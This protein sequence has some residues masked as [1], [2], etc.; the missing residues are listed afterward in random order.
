MTTA[1]VSQLVGAGSAVGV[2]LV[3][4]PIPNP[5]AAALYALIAATVGWVVTWILNSIKKRLGL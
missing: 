4:L 1:T 5:I 2:S 3:A